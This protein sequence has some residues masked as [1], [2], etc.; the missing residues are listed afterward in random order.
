MAERSAA[1][2]PTSGGA[3]CPS[4][5]RL[6]R[7]MACF[8]RALG[9]HSSELRLFPV[10]TAAHKMTGL[11]AQRYGLKGRGELK[12]GAFADIVAFE[13]CAVSEKFTASGR[14]ACAQDI[15]HVFIDGSLV[16]WDG[17]SGA[18]FGPAG[19][20]GGRESTDA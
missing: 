18:T 4:A 12:K 5:R 2:C 10:E 20:R 19:C 6:P 13:P 16:L 15:S 9:H 3:R 8:P 1:N 17:C 14:P 7:P 11:S